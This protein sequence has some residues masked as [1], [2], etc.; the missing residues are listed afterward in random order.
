MPKKL[1]VTV[2]IP[3]KWAPAVTGADM[4]GAQKKLA[5]AGSAL[6]IKVLKVELAP[7]AV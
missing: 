6:G 1:L 7:D 2:E 4:E 5:M 3:D